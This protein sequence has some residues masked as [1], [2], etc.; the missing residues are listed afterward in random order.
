[1]RTTL[2]RLRR[3]GG[4][5]HG[6]TLVEL[7]VVVVIIGVLAAI[8][9]PMFLSYQRTSHDKAAQSDAHAA[10]VAMENCYARHG[11]YPAVSGTTAKVTF[12][13]S[14]TTEG[15]ELSKSTVLTV[16]VTNDMPATY[17]IDAYNTEGNGDAA[18]GVHYC[19][20]S[21]N[22]GALNENTGTC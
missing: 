8:A 10:V 19:Y 7:L 9:I 15:I 22:G 4:Q 13:G 16:T 2:T 12:T 17:T 20:D 3:R 14:C 18:G 1:M 6:F 5:D 21:E 11:E